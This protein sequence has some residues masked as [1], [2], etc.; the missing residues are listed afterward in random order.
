MGFIAHKVLA[1]VLLIFLEYISGEFELLQSLQA[2]DF[3]AQ[4]CLL[5]PLDVRV[6][7]VAFAAGL[8]LDPLGSHGYN[9][10]SIRTQGHS[11]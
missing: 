4:D 9:F 11:Y 1:E 5:L 8:S 6:V 2:K 7:V 3:E 10:I